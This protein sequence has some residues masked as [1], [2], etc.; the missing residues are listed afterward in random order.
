M[1]KFLYC[2]SCF[3]ITFYQDGKLGSLSQ[4]KDQFYISETQIIGE[5]IKP[6]E[7]AEIVR[8]SVTVITNDKDEIIAKTS[9][10]AL[11]YESLSTY[12]CLCMA[13]AFI[14]GYCLIT[15]DKTLQKKCVMNNIEVKTSNDVEDEF[16]NGGG[17]YENMRE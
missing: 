5:L 6:D 3:L 2:D 7:L 15:D 4:Y 10:F 17:R 9:E 1:K 12:D 16:L 11:K 8:K 14:D 13:Y